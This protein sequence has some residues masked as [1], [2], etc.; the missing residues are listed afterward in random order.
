MILDKTCPTLI[1]FLGSLSD[2]IAIRRCS[3]GAVLNTP[4]KHHTNKLENVGVLKMKKPH[5]DEALCVA[6]PCGDCR[7]TAER[8]ASPC[9]AKKIRIVCPPVVKVTEPP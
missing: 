2:K 8:G 4:H 1:S 5:T 7:I 9:R 6:S 3:L